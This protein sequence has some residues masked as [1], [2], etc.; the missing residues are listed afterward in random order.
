M[1]AGGKPFVQYP[2][3]PSDLRTS[4]LVHSKKKH[5]FPIQNASYMLH[6]KCLSLVGQFNNVLSGGH[7]VSASKSFLCS[8]SKSITDYLSGNLGSNVGS[9]DN[10]YTDDFNGL[11]SSTSGID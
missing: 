11:L 9:E 7:F 2:W 4:V 6:D 5:S 3:L 10:T 1:A 8:I